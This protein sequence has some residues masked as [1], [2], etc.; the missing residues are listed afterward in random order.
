M[1]SVIIFTALAVVL[2]WVIEE[3]GASHHIDDFIKVGEPKSDECVDNM[4][5]MQRISYKL[6][7]PIKEKK[8]E[9]VHLPV[10]HFQE[11]SWIPGLW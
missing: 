5:R 8:T 11:L 3:N 1:H 4:V 2:Q 6:G 9:R 10:K 7:L